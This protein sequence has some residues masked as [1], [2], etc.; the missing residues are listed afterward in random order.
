VWLS[1]VA[2]SS[3]ELSTTVGLRRIHL[4][5]SLVDQEQGSH[6]TSASLLVRIRRE[7]HFESVRIEEGIRP[8]SP[9]LGEVSNLVLCIMR[10]RIGREDVE[11]HTTEALGA[12]VRAA[13]AAHGVRDEVFRGAIREVGGELGNEAP[14][15]VLLSLTQRLS[16]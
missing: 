6:Q 5:V 13:A 2:E 10:S 3:A 9:H 14:A 8:S 11:W 4:E 15:H 7:I 12:A 1:L 16:S